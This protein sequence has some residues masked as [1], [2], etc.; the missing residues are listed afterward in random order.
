M[1]PRDVVSGVG[2]PQESTLNVRNSPYMV[3]ISQ[4]FGAKRPKLAVFA[5]IWLSIGVFRVI[6]V[7]AED[8]TAGLTD[9]LIHKS[10]G[11]VNN[12]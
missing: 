5:E 3:I 11:A 4:N 6:S 2:H 7:S 8:R 12:R 9:Q 1:P 10:W